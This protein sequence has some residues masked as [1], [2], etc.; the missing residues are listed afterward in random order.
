[1]AAPSRHSLSL[2]YSA[3]T[4][5]KVRQ[6]ALFAS[7]MSV[8]CPALHALHARAGAHLLPKSRGPGVC[9]SNGEQALS[10]R[11]TRTVIVGIAAFRRRSR[12]T[13]SVF[14]FSDTL[15]GNKRI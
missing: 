15:L 13:R 7:V 2:P 14:S 6:H 4:A 10:R 1:M 12:P 5:T 8:C 9:P 11:A 3:L